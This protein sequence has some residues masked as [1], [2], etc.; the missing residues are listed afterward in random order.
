MEALETEQYV[1]SKVSPGFIPFSLGQPDASLLPAEELSSAITRAAAR[2]LEQPFALQ[3]GK[4]AGPDPFRAELSRFLERQHGLG[5]GGVDPE[6]LAM[7]PGN[8]MGLSLLA[9]KLASLSPSPSPCCLVESPSYFLAEAVLREAGLEPIAV[10]QGE[11]FAEDAVAVMRERRERGLDPPALWVVALPC[12]PFPFFLFS[13]PTSDQPHRAAS[14][15]SPPFTIQRR[16]RSALPRGARCS[17]RP[18]SLALSSSLTSLTT[19]CAL[20]GARVKK[21][22]E[23]KKKKKKKK[24]KRRKPREC[25]CR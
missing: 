16:R 3:Y 13:S 17:P 22:K 2:V 24:K 1:Q 12:F 19:C 10:A 21:K 6:S 20:R 9:Q 18:R 4:Q 7:T 23:K 25:R 11:H 5:D 14:T 8:S 15:P